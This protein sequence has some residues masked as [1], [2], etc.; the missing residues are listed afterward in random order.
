MLPRPMMEPATDK[1]NSSLLLHWPRSSIFSSEGGCR[2]LA[3]LLPLG[4][5]AVAASP[6][7]QT[8]RGG[9]LQ[10]V[11]EASFCALDNSQDALKQKGN[12]GTI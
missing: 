4:R 3:W 9:G 8:E 12:S 6:A 2:S 7:E 5:P 1:I 11:M 10:Q